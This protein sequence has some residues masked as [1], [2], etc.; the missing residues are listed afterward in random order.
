MGE[1]SKNVKKRPAD[2]ILK[3]RH[4]VD[5]HYATEKAKSG[6]AAKEAASEAAKKY[7]RES[8]YVKP[9]V[10]VVKSGDAEPY[11]ISGGAGSTANAGR[12]SGSQANHHVTDSKNHTKTVKGGSLGGGALGIGEFI[13]Q[14][15]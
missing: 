2:E 12:P 11:K 5:S 6:A 10:I 1:D 9:D 4:N 7:K 13:E 15:K 3:L 14:I 8:P